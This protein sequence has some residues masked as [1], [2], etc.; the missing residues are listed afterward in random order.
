MSYSGHAVSS[1]FAP[2][3]AAAASEQAEKNGLSALDTLGSVCRFRRGETIFGE[4]D[5]LRSSYK[6]I[7]GAVRLS[8]ITEDGRR[9]IV[10]FRTAGD[11]VGFEWKGQYALGAEAVRDV[12]AVRFM[13]TRVDRLIEERSDV[14]DSLVAIIRE[15]LRAAHEHLITLGCRAR[16]SGSPISCCSSPARRG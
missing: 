16:R 12:V 9:Q 2:V 1:K 7:S 3:V 11:F 14:R 15:E 13:R 10:E 4:G 6:I 5:E 8:R